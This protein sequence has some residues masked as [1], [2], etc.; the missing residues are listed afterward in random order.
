MLSESKV[1]YLYDYKCQCGMHTLIEI[2]IPEN[3]VLCI[4][5]T[6]IPKDPTGK[7]IICDYCKKPAIMLKGKY[8]PIDGK[9]IS[10]FCVDS[11]LPGILITF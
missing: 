9:L 4:E 3:S 1:K 11:T 2:L 5:D 6:L 7:D 8:H 10:E